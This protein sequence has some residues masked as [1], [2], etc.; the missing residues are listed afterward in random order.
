MIQNEKKEIEIYTSTSKIDEKTLVDY[1]ARLYF[2]TVEEKHN[3]F[4]SIR[5]IVEVSNEEVSEI[6][7][8]SKRSGNVWRR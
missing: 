1:F 7:W 3:N 8:K 4:Y 5:I 2:T 6:V